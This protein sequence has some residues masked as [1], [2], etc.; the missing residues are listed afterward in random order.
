[1]LS[2]SDLQTDKQS[3]LQKQLFIK[4]N[5]PAALRKPWRGIHITHIGWQNSS[6]M[7]YIYLSV[8]NTADLKQKTFPLFILGNLSYVY[9]TLKI[10]FS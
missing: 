8:A 10:C 7:K 3:D 6:N 1:M 2:I 4:E 5:E 9:T